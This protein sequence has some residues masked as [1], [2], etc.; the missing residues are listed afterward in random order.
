[1]HIGHPELLFTRHIN[2]VYEVNGYS[3]VFMLVTRVICE[4]RAKSVHRVEMIE[5]SL[6]RSWASSFR[7]Y[8]LLWTTI[9]LVGFLL[10]DNQQS[11]NQRAI[12][13]FTNLE[14]IEVEFLKVEMES[15]KVSEETMNVEIQTWGLGGIES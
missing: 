11:N 7:I 6:T 5:Q 15:I 12:H 3:T 9:F 1:M 8:L 13:L 10:I 4:I 2:K 14:L